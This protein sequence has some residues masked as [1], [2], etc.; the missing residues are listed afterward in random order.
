MRGPKS[1]ARIS[2]SETISNS[3]N[4]NDQNSLFDSIEHCLGHWNIR[5]L[6][7]FRA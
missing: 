1:E 4:S 5:I 3:Q 6:N 2:K 7:L